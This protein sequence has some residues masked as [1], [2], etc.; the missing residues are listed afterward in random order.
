MEDSS[1]D[2]SKAFAFLAEVNRAHRYEFFP[3]ETSADRFAINVYFIEHV[4]LLDCLECDEVMNF[5]SGVKSHFKLNVI[6]YV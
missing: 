4:K 2:F 3:V 5:A 6:I 1:K